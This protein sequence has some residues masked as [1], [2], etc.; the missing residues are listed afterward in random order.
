MVDL[1]I[2]HLAVVTRAVAAQKNYSLRAQKEGGDEI[3]QLVDGLNEMLAQIQARDAELQMARDNLERRVE[4]RTEDLQQEVEERRRAQEAL[5]ESQALYSSLVEQLPMGVFRKDREG[6]YVFLNSWFCRLKDIQ[7]G[8][9][10]DKT[11]KELAAAE[12]SGHKTLL[13]NVTLLADQGTDHHKTIMETGRQIEMEEEYP[14]VEGRPQY[15]Q[16]VKLPVF[17]PDGKTITGSQGIMFDITARKQAELALQESQA[18]YHSLVEQ[19]PTGIFRKD[20][21]GRYVFVNSRFCQIKCVKPEQVLGKI[22]AEV[23]AAHSAAGDAAWNAKLRREG[24]DHHQS[25]LQN[26]RHIEVEEEYLGPDG[27]V[28]HLHVVKLPVFGPDGRITGSQGVMIDITERKR[29]EAEAAYERDLLSALMDSLPDVIYFKDL[30]SRF[31]RVSASKAEKEF[32]VALSL[33]RDA[34]PGEG[35]ENLPAH[36]RSLE[37][38]TRFMMGKT[39]ADFLPEAPAHSF[40]EEEQEII[41]TGKPLIGDLVHAPL[42]N[43]KTGWYLRTKMPWRDKNGKIVGTFGISKDVTSIKEAQAELAYERDLFQAL[44]ENFPDTIYFK[45]RQSKFVRVSRTK[46]EKA[47]EFCLEQHRKAGGT[48]DDLPDH[49]R[50]LDRFAGYMIGKSDLDFMLPEVARAVHEEEQKIIR[51]G[52]PVIGEVTRVTLLDGKVVWFLS[53]KLP[54]KDKNGN[55]VGVFGTSKDVTSIKEAEAKLAEASALMTTLLASTP[56]HIYFKDRESRF[57]R[58]SASM[59]HLFK[60][61]NVDEVVGR[62]DHDFFAEEH[63]RPAFEDEQEIIRTGNTDHRQDRAETYPDG[64]V[65]WCLTTKMPWHGKDG[66]IIGTFGISKDITAIKEAEDKL[67]TVHKQLVETSRQAGMAEVATS[68]LHNVGN[69][70]NSVN[71]SAAWSPTGCANPR[72]RASRGWWPCLQEHERDLGGIHQPGRDRA[73]S[74]PAT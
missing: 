46:L 43:G 64:R 18:L 62:S 72:C 70:L 44:M 29:A 3:G 21:Q 65:T 39:D 40:S 74:C 53:S 22:T 55:I 56:D 47:L 4:Q 51:T 16:V 8:E 30:E 52:K 63:A 45:D 37:Q 20:M 19:M 36:L 1:R 11:P 28:R 41:R 5:Q 50:G 27:Q 71:V 68:V 14:A 23:V 2:R 54:W 49:L 32:K 34:H 38:F 60:V 31:V 73:I 61:D 33:H 26:G 59:A 12:L 69:V 35:A 58:C 6:R 13:P 25:I 67:E 42:L 15:L 24:A 17:G 66:S 48:D 9:M 57:I 10:L 7:P